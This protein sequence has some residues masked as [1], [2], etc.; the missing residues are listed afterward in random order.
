M[1]NLSIKQGQK[2]FGTQ[3]AE[4]N[5]IRHN[6]NFH[7]TNY[8]I[9]ETSYLVA[10]EIEKIKKMTHNWR[11]FDCALKMIEIVL[12]S[13]LEKSLLQLLYQLN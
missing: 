1:E 4:I 8:K 5:K 9:N 7:E 12:K 2:F 13:R 3:C 6:G 11:Y 10:L